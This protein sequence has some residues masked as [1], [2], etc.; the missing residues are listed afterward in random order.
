M[1]DDGNYALSIVGY[2]E[3][4][5]E[6]LELLFADPHIKSNR[7]YGDVGLYRKTFDL[8]GRSKNEDKRRA[9]Q[10]NES[11]YNVFQALEFENKNWMIC[12]IDS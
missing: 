1:I 12:F 10:V 6:T 7:Q 5:N 9:W 3:D 4:S 11:L 2:K 8:E